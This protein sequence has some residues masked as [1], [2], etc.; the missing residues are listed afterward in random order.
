MCGIHNFEALARIFF[1][2]DHHARLLQL[3]SYMHKYRYRFYTV[4]H[5]IAEIIVLKIEEELSMIF[6]RTNLGD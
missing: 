6:W 3:G 5:A 4:P 1:L 2:I